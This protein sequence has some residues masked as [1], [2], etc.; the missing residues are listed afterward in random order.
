MWYILDPI[1]KL[2][3][4]VY[5]ENFENTQNDILSKLAATANIQTSTEKNKSPHDAWKLDSFQN[6]HYMCSPKKSS[7]KEK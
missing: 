3:I 6:S 2:I 4:A 5:T 7:F 1:L